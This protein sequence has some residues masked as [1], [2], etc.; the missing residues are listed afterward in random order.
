MTPIPPGGEQ[1][2]ERLACCAEWCDES[3]GRTVDAAGLVIE[4]GNVCPD[5]LMPAMTRAEFVGY[6]ESAAKQAIQAYR[7]CLEEEGDSH[8]SAS[9]QALLEVEDTTVCFAGI[10]SCG[11][12]WCDHG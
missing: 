12:K 4:H 7:F 2:D 10:G 11:R 8:E 1:R 5:G 9:D 3:E 6:C